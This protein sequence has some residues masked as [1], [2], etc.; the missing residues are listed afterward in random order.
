MYYLFEE[1]DSD[2]TSCLH[3]NTLKNLQN[4][5]Y[6]TE[7]TSLLCII[8]R[9]KYMHLNAL[10]LWSAKEVRTDE[11]WLELMRLGDIIKRNSN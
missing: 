7:Q 5:G 10:K 8:F 2:A 1:L 3:P 9:E 6:I 11:R 4:H